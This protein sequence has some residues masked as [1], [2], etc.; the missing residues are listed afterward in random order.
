[1]SS[2]VNYCWREVLCINKNNF[3]YIFQYKLYLILQFIL[4]ICI[5]SVIL[6]SF[7]EIERV[8]Q[9]LQTHT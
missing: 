6:S 3:L 8:V 1:M 4:I 7:K 2:V 9:V 5:Y